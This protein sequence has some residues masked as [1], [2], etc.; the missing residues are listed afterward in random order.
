MNAKTEHTDDRDAILLH[1]GF[2][3]ACLLVLAAP[4][5]MPV[6]QRV[7]GLALL[8]NVALA[9]LYLAQTERGIS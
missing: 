5:T 9:S 1:G 7:S 3:L 8:H 6:G 4:L 2:A